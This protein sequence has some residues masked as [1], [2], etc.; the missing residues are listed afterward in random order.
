[1][2]ELLQAM[3]FSATPQHRCDKLRKNSFYFTFTDV[4]ETMLL[5]Y[6]GASE[7]TKKKHFAMILNPLNKCHINF[8]AVFR[9]AKK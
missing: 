6:A 1:M 4:V 2:S 7:R 8:Q 9:A 3:P 5:V